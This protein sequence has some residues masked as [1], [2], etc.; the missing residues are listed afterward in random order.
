MMLTSRTFGVAAFFEVFFFDA[1][2][3]FLLRFF[4]GMFPRPPLSRLTIFRFDDVLYATRLT[5]R[6]KVERI[7]GHVCVRGFGGCDRRRSGNLLRC[8]AAFWRFLG[9][10]F[11]K[12]EMTTLARLKLRRVVPHHIGAG[13]KAHDDLFL[14]VVALVYLIDFDNCV[15]PF[16]IVFANWLAARRGRS[17]ERGLR[18]A[19]CLFV[20]RQRHREN[21]SGNYKIRFVEMTATFTIAVTLNRIDCGAEHCGVGGLDRFFT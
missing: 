7:E 3:A 21:L 4:A 2:E 14:R 13:R 9:F 19:L 10:T 20:R 8:L 1:F 11:L 5:V 16:W 12:Q 17:S 6:L 15:A 18:G